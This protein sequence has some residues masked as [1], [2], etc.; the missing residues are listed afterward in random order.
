MLFRSDLGIAIAIT[1]CLNDITADMK[2]VLIGE[3]GLSGEIRPVNDLEKRINEAQKLGFKRAIVP[4]SNNIKEKFK[5]IEVVEV[6][7]IIDA[8]TASIKKEG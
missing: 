3:I 5:N 8:I 2:T 6:K 4:A 7:R 1:T